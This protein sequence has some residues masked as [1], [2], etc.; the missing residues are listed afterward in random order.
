MITSSVAF[1][2]FSFFSV[3]GAND[4]SDV[5]LRLPF[6][7]LRTPADAG[8]LEATFLLVFGSMI[9]QSSSSPAAEEPAL[10]QQQVTKHSSVSRT[11][12]SVQTV[13]RLQITNHQH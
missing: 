1:D 3:S 8:P 9:M 12:E 11:V 7:S 4:V 2:S 13:H 6:A 5:R 10:Q